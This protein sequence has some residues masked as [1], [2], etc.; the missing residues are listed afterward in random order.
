MDNTKALKDLREVAAV[1]E[2]VGDLKKAKVVHDAADLIEKQ[3][4][5]ITKVQRYYTM[6][7]GRNAD[8]VPFYISEVIKDTMGG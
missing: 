4:K 7:T 6:H 2:S 1:L 8:A 3:E 5:I